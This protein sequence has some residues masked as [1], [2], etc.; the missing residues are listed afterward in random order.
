MAGL[1]CATFASC[2][3]YLDVDAPSK[4]DDS[5]VF[6]T[7]TEMNRALN[8][9]YAQLLSGDVYG[10]KFLSDLCLNSDVEFAANATENP[11]SGGFRRF[12]CTS[13]A[14]QLKKTWDQ[15]YSGI[16][17]ANNFIYQTENSPLYQEGNANVYQ[18][19]GEAKVIRAMFY[20]DLVDLWGDV[21]FTFTPTSHKEDLV[22]PIVSRDE[23]R[24]KLIEDL[25]A[26]APKM[27]YARKLENTVEHV[28][29]EAC[30]A[31]IS[32]LA[33][34]AGGYSLRPDKNDATSHGKM[35][36]PENYKEFYTIA[37]NYADSVIL[38]NTHHLTKS[39]R[40]VFIDE[41]NFVVDNGDDPIFEIPFAKNSSGNIGYIHGPSASL[42][43]GVSI[44]PN[45]WG[46]TKGGAQVSALYGYS[47]DPQDVRRDYVVGM[48]SYTNQGDTTCVPTIKADYTLFN[49]KWSKLWSNSGNFANNSAG[50]TGINFPYLRYTDVLLMFAEAENELNDGPTD[51]AKDALKTVRRRAFDSA[52]W[53]EKV[54]QYVDSVSQAGVGER[55]NTAKKAFLRAVLNERK[56]EFAGENMRWKDLVRNNM[57]S[58]VLY[59]T[60][61]RYYALGENAGGTSNYMD[62][63][64][65]YDFGQEAGRYDNLPFS[66]FWRRVANPKDTNKYPNTALEVLEIAN[67]Y[68]LQEKKPSDPS[69]ITND[70]YRWKETQNNFGWWNEGAGTPTNQCLYS[71]YGFMRGNAQGQPALVENNGSLSTVS[72][73]DANMTADKLPVVRYILPY[74]NAAIQRSGGTYKNY[75]GYAN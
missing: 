8:G 10:D 33:L 63:V 4:Y 43:S 27:Q 28:S 6:A 40:N 5:Y 30:W 15:I 9:V 52:N 61:L 34:A 59:Y 55:Y 47:F 50:N 57:Y 71:L 75:Y 36:R 21:P 23:V 69:E 2:N 13:D 45:V 58:E 51:A 18:M 1:A 24:T 65:M 32:R 11:T 48:W 70:E 49:N 56:W 62:A 16:E 46:E 20:N 35:E 60:F 25:R 72:S 64:E 66:I 12:D 38:S 41:C 37:R 67:P 31:M 29:K 74:P 14:S 3:D 39:Y 42:S 22:T 68:N 54:D 53:P 17:Y 73:A 19:L 7:E 44:A 26:I